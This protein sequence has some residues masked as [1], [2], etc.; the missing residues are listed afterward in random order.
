MRYLLVDMLDARGARPAV[1]LKSWDGSA[2][3]ACL[4]SRLDPRPDVRENERVEVR[5]ALRYQ[6]GGRR[7]EPV[8][9]AYV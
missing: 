3:R 8:L 1:T 5:H 7:C 2:P 6:C 9:T 4:G